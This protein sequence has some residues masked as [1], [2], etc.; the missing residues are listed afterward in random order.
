MSLIATRSGWLIGCRIIKETKKTWIVRPW[1][2]IKDQRVM[3]DDPDRMV[4]DDF[5]AAER[6]ANTGERQ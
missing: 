2:S 5:E 3:K 1:D 6:F 4:T